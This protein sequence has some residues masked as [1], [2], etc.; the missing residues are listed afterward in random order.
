MG[1]LKKKNYVAI[2]KFWKRSLKIMKKKI[3]IAR[4]LD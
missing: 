2:S 3:A 4:K 1:L